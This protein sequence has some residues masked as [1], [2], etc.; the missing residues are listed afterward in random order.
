M[1]FDFLNN[2]VK[3]RQMLGDDLEENLINRNDQIHIAYGIDNKFVMPMGVAIISILKHNKHENILFHVLVEELNS[4]NI[5]Y[6]KQLVNDYQ[7][8]MVIHYIDAGI[9]DKLPSTEHFTKATYNRFLLTKV[10]KNTAKRV[11]YLDAD[12]L[13]YGS[14]SELK[15]LDFQGNIVAVVQDIGAVANRQI[16]KLQLMH[17]RYFN[18]GFL[19]IDIEQWEQN[20]ISEKALQFSFAHLGKLNWLDQDALNVVLND[21]ALFIEEKY[22]YIFDFGIK[23]NC[24]I[25]K[26]PAEMVFVHYA[27][28]NKPWHAWCMHPLQNDFLKYL[29]ISPWKGIALQQPQNYKEM[30]KMAQSYMMYGQ[31]RKSFIWYL[32]YAYHKI[33]QKCEARC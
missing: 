3:C 20:C 13:C 7:F 2:P 12:I 18:A 32:R 25:D 15:N 31:L 8:K 17:H 19:Y 4:D 10:L 14:I 29:Q 21:K 16:E 28:R 22:D 5:A 9:F 30:K 1:N 27:G 23:E 24:H 6:L 33:K 26:M 11:I